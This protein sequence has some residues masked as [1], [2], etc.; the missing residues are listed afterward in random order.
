MEERLNKIK[1][2]F[3]DVDN[4]LL[5]LKMRDRNGRRVVG[6]PNYEEWLK[7]NITTN[8]YID[9]VAPKGMSNII[10][11]LHDNGAK[12]YGLT[13]CSNSFEYNSKYNRLKECYPG[14]FEHHGDLISID[15]R[16]RKILIMQMIAERDNLN[17]D[18]I[19]F[20]DDS[21]QEVME[22]FDKG[23]LSMHTTE[24]IE[25]F[26]E[27][28]VLSKNQITKDNNIED[29]LKIAA[30]NQIDKLKNDNVYF[31]DEQII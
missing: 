21:Y 12:V 5:C 15:T 3:A 1:A 28:P 7:Y 17:S 31:F 26:I 11:T 2:V 27:P 19:M 8:A 30:N 4:T 25:R 23:F 18:E 22:A 10:N 29:D 13:E 6:F 14:V 20:I 24:A 16:H 9:C